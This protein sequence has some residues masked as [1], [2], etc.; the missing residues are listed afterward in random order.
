MTPIEF[1]GGCALL[2]LAAGVFGSALGVGSGIIMVPALVI[3]FHFPQKSAQ[4][5]SLAVMALM[6]GVAAMR[7]WGD[8]AI[9]MDLR[10]AGVI[11][12]FAMG[13]AVAGVGLV[14]VAPVGLL[15]KIFAILLVVVAVRLAFFPG[16]GK[17]PGNKPT[18]A[19]TTNPGEGNHP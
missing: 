12:L 10:V 17:E 11:A 18:P 6:A 3:L 15:Q 13:G 14:R 19:G 1:W 9:R 7:Y 4:G 2:G 5:I 16:N 8:P